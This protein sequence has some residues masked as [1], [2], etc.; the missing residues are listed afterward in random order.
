MFSFSN[1]ISSSS[2]FIMQISGKPQKTVFVLAICLEERVS[3]LSSRT[4]STSI[5]LIATGKHEHSSML[6]WVERYQIGDP[7]TRD[8]DGIALSNP[9]Q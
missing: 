1:V 9:F 3:P 4:I 2:I 7:N 6:T 5:K 8:K